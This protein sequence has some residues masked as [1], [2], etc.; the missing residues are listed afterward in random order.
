ME[1]KN[2]KKCIQKKEVLSAVTI[3]SS[4]V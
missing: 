3:H 4:I 2:T 1:E